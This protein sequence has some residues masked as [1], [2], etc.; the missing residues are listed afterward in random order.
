MDPVA[1]HLG[2]LTI[3]WY[4]ICVAAGF[5]VG[6]QWIQY[7]A[8]RFGID[9]DAASNLVLLAMGGGILGGRILYVVQNWDY[10]GQFPAEIPRVDHGGLVFYGG[11]LG[12]AAVLYL[13]V[14]VK[15]YSTGEVADLF[16][17]ALPLS[18]AI[19]RVGCFLNGCCFGHPSTGPVAV[20][21]PAGGEVLGVQKALGLVSDNAHECLP[22]LPVQLL[23]AFTNLCVFLGLLAVAKRRRRA[24]EILAAYLALSALGRFL[25]EFG[26]GDYVD[27]TGVLSPAQ[28]ICLV[29][30]PFG[31][32]LLL[33]L[34]RPTVGEG[35]E[36]EHV[37]AASPATGP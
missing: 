21:Y 11:F 36:E 22:V 28:L 5:L 12:T 8:P 25:V 9:R 34:R 4:G 19:G 29:L 26:R 23:A 17:S 3:R 15:R 27:R 7:R 35:C 10:F 6:F 1:L 13:A 24:G 2:P 31:V 14:R 18:H 33:V 20:R 16:S 32:G 30:F 37:T